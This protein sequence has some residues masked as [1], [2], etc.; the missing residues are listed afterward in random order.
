MGIGPLLLPSESLNTG[1]RS[2]VL[3][4]GV[5][6][7]DPSSLSKVKCFKVMEFLTPYDSP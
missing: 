3:S 4:S 2:A 5:T 1:I 6:T 7:A